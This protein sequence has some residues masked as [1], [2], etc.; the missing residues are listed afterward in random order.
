MRPENTTLE[1]KIYDAT[2]DLLMQKDPDQ[3]GMR[4]IAAKC[5]VTATAI[6]RYYQDKEAIF[7]KISVSCL[8][9]IKSR[10]EEKIL[11][12]S[13]RRLRVTEA[14]RAFRDWCFENPRKAALIM[15]RISSN[16]AE[17][18]QSPFYVCNAFGE[19][20]IA[21]CAA[22]GL[23]R[24]IDVKLDTGIIIYSLWGCIEAVFQKRVDPIFWNEGIAFT[25]RCI[26]LIEKQL[27]GGAQ[28]PRR[29]I[30]R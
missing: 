26:E 19:Q 3:I 25:D 4:D 5:S 23:I 17:Q 1:Q 9:E 27:F 21:D 29:K 6:Y 20:L 28:S 14:L 7:K 8:E 11:P 16:A 10:M 15:G 30:L 24:D 22:A 2:L 12:V 13:D 18:D